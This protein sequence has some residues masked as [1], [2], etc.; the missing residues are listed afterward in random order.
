MLNGLLIEGFPL[1]LAQPWIMIDER[2]FEFTV[3]AKAASADLH[4]ALS[5]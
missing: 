5:A 1:M 4:A 3:F 2:F